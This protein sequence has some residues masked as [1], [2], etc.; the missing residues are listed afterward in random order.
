MALSI[1]KPADFGATANYHIID[2]IRYDKAEDQTRISLAGWADK[3]VRLAYFPQAQVRFTISVVG[4]LVSLAEA[5][6]IVKQTPEWANA[7]D[8]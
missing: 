4:P 5:Y 7:E 8:C 3:E 2:G 1:A 6:T